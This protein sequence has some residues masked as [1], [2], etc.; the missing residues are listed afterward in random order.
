MCKSAEITRRASAALIATMLSVASATEAAA[1]N[2]LSLVYDAEK[3]H[4]VDCNS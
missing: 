2:L 4:L 3:D 1:A